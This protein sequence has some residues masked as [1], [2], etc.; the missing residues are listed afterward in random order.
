MRKVYLENLPRYKNRDQIDWEN[1]VGHIV[2]FV[3]DDV[4][5]EFKII[6]CDK[7]N[8]KNIELTIEYKNEEFIVKTGYLYKGTIRKILNKPHFDIRFLFSVGDIL[9]NENR[10]LTITDKKIVERTQKNEKC[11]TGFGNHY[12]KWYK[13]T[14][15]VC[16]WT[17]GWDTEGHLKEGRGCS[18]CSGNTVVE[19]INS[20]TATAPEIIKY[21]T[22]KEDA[23]KFTCQSS[24]RVSCQC[25]V[26][27]YIKMVIVANLYKQGF[28]CPRCSDN[29]S[30]AEKFIMSLLEQL[31]IDYV[32]QLTHTKLKWVG[33]YKYDFYLH[34]YECI[35]EVHGEQHYIENGWSEA[36]T[37][38]EE[39][40]NDVKKRN[41]AISNGIKK[42]ITLDARGCKKANQDDF[43]KEIISSELAN[44]FDLSCVNWTK[45]LEYATTSFV[46]RVCD[47]YNE[48]K[49]N[50]E[51]ISP[52]IL[53]EKFKLHHSTIRSYLVLGNKCGL[54]EYDGKMARSKPVDVYKNDILVG[55][56][57]SIKG[58]L[59]SSEEQYGVKFT[60]SGIWTACD[61]DKLYHGYIIK[62]AGSGERT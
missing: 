55:T 62:S 9:C 42:Y 47:Y 31:G 21:L 51:Y 24:K 29:I 61:K 34:E 15:N 39:Q 52:S 13:Y 19:E 32:Y 58:L 28:S 26:C 44:Q 36:R 17:E 3:Y 53:S 56:H 7:S 60:P 12:D 50:G 27:G 10:N 25:P 57:G 48:C 11:K 6:S 41:L 43:I 20:I 16:G 54:C 8:T 2:Q 30:M 35:I 37:L 5:D 38:Q 1:S 22:N 4:V 59:E 45:C 40:A 18:C 49:L 14:C 23:K 33:S 46:K